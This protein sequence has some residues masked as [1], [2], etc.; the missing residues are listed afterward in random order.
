METIKDI[1]NFCFGA[2]FYEYKNVRITEDLNEVRKCIFN[3]FDETIPHTRIHVSLSIIDDIILKSNC[4]DFENI[5]ENIHDL[6]E[7]IL[8]ILLFE[9]LLRDEQHT[10]RTVE[11][12]ILPEFDENK[13][14]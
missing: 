11:D 5:F 8:Y 13:T 6:R 10:I 12:S 3:S 2:V 1:L 4:G 9:K 7:N 14:Q